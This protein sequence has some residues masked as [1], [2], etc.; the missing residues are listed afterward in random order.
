MGQTR[1]T[2]R[3][4][5][6]LGMLAFLAGCAG[7]PMVWYRDGATQQEFSRDSYECERESWKLPKI[8]YGLA[9]DMDHSHMTRRMYVQCMQARGYELR[10]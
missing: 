9:G 1:V 3:A 2:A 7:K 4:V 5:L 10:R 8:G 6:I